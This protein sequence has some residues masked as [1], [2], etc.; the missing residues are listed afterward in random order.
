MKKEER[1]LG[2]SGDLRGNE[3]HKFYLNLF[4]FIAFISVK[5]H[6]VLDR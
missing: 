1:L 4:K 5:N 6:M 3:R 2:D